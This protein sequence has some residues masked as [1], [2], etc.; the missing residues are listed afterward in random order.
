M[1]F[2]RIFWGLR[3]WKRHGKILT[4]AGIVYAMVGI[5]YI[6]R[7]NEGRNSS[8]RVLLNVAP[9]SFWGGVF[10]FAGVLAI[11]SSRWPRFSETWGYVVLT[12]LSAGW[13]SAYLMG[14]LFLGLPWTNINGFFVWGLFGYLWWGISG[15]ANPHKLPRKERPD[16]RSR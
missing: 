9:M 4:G 16:A 5:A 1:K 12:S 8:L 2:D 10:V 7:P 6:V 3:P 13:G 14:I 15:L 11:I